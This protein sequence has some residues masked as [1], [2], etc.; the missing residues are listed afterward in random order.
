MENSM[1][2]MEVFQKVKNRITIWTSN[3]IS[4]KLSKGNESSISKRYLHSHVH[5]SSTHNSQGMETSKCLL[6]DKRRSKMWYMY[7]MEYY[8]SLKKGNIAIC[9]NMKEP[10]GHYDK[11]NKPDTEI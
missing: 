6:L 3:S 5:C 10:G 2:N 4:G 7:T 11:W 9:N 1:E 8:L